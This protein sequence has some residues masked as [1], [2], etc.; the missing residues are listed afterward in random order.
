[1]WANKYGQMSCFKEKKSKMVIFGWFKDLVFN[2][3]KT[4]DFSFDKVE[5]CTI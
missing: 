2:N 3:L 5:I 1:M 4:P